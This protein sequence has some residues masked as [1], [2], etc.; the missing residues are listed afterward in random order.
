MVKKCLKETKDK[1]RWEYLMYA[2]NVECRYIKRTMKDVPEEQK[3]LAHREQLQISRADACPHQ[4]LKS[5]DQSFCVLSLY[6]RVQSVVCGSAKN[7]QGNRDQTWA[8]C[9]KNM[10]ANVFL[11]LLIV[12]AKRIIKSTNKESECYLQCVR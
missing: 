7:E 8:A 2:T 5:C 12:L 6:D 11:V 9:Q 1:K 10:P 3:A 4:Q